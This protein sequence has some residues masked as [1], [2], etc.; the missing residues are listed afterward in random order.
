MADTKKKRRRA[1]LE[2]FHKGKDGKYVYQGEVYTFVGSG[3]QKQKQELRSQLR[4]LWVC[5][6]VMLGSLAASGCVRAPGMD[7][8]FY[9]L[10]PYAACLIAGISVCWAMCRLTSGGNPLKAYVYEASVKALPV[11]TILA[12]LS[13]GA[14]AAGEI[15]YVLRHGMEGKPAGFCVF[16]IL[17]GFVIISSAVIRRKVLSMQWVK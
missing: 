8:C 15:I 12:A 5:C 7:N 9:V 10:L 14:G 1:Y 11:R 2:S 13:A 17:Y 3:Q 4:N 16:L 6:G